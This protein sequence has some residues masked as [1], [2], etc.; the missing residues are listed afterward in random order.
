MVLRG[1]LVTGF[2]VKYT[3]M[4]FRVIGIHF[5]PEFLALSLDQVFRGFQNLIES[6]EV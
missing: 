1:P 6:A 3:V 2:L 4:D 5:E